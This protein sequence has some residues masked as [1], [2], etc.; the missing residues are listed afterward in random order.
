MDNTEKLKEEIVTL[1]KKIEEMK[2]KM[3]AHSTPVTMMQDLEDLEDELDK[4]KKE[5]SIRK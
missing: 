4:K 5:L 2:R 1:E 3:S